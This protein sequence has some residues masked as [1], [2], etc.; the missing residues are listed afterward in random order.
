VPYA[1]FTAD[2][3][4]ILNGLYYGTLAAY[5]LAWG[6]TAAQPKW[7]RWILGAGVLA[8]LVAT[9]WRGVLIQ[10]FPLTNKLESFST[11]AICIAI[12]ALL[13]WRPN[14]IYLLTLL[15]AAIAALSFAITFPMDLAFPPPLM[16]TIW[17][18]LHIP[19]SFFAYGLWTAAAAAG[20]AWLRDRD[21]TWLQRIDRMAL[22]GFGLWSLS[23][24]CGGVWGV[25]AWGAYFMWDPKIIWSVILWFHYAS[26]IHLRLTPSLQGRSW[27]R[28]VFAF[29]GI[30]FV[31]V[32]YVGT[33]F[34]FGKG[35]HAFG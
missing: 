10:F 31:F 33:S 12:V 29:A 22:Q 35:S 19:M 13:S 15:A 27:V 8:H 7:G 6:V 5:A 17:Y 3:H 30:A 18:P 26:F 20:L 1:S 24:I 16:Q 4:P 34:L 21:P 25:L 2:A 14:R 32:A 28:P 11:A 23:M 9:I